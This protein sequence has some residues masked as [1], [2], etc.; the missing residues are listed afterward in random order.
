MQGLCFRCVIFVEH[1]KQQK[2]RPGDRKAIK[3]QMKSCKSKQQIGTKEWEP[4]SSLRLY[5]K[6][7]Y[8]ANIGDSRLYDHRDIDKYRRTTVLYG[9]S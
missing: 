4:P 1:I 2:H 7:M 6:E 5:D 3:I 9:N 8:V